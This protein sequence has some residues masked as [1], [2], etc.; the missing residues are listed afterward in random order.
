MF[1][2]ERA[3]ELL[4]F[5]GEYSSSAPDELY[6]DFVMSAPPGGKPG[7]IVIAPCWSGPAGDAERVFAPIR[8]LGKPLADTI[9]GPRLRAPCS[10]CTTASTRATKAAT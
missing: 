4:D 2:I 7:V 1:P 6:V 5:Y 3:R 10:A 8:K 9:T